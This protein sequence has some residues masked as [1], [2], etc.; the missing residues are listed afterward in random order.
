M[1]QADFINW[2]EEL[3]DEERAEKRPFQVA[4]AIGKDDQEIVEACRKAQNLMHLAEYVQDVVTEQAVFA[5]RAKGMTVRQIEELT[6]IPK[7]KA[8]RVAKAQK[9]CENKNYAIAGLV[10]ISH[11]AQ[12]RNLR[13][14]WDK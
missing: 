10:K 12:L 7:S 5:L 6:G 9:S 13:Q 14:M 11:E 2:A 3:T 4:F 8:G 1:G